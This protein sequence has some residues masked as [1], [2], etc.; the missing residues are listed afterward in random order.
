M[1]FL[2]KI[3]GMLIQ[4][5]LTAAFILAVIG[6]ALVI[7][8][9]CQQP[10]SSEYGDQF[11]DAPEPIKPLPY[12]AWQHD[13]A[14]DPPKQ[15]TFT[16]KFVIAHVALI[17]ATVYDSEATHQGIAHHKCLEQN[18]ALPSRPSRADLYE[19]GMIPVLVMTGFDILVQSRHFEKKVG[20]IAYMAP[21]YGTAIHIYGAST[22]LQTGC[23]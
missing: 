14:G 12:G 6:I 13:S 22:W 15:K 1:R 20:W 11:P 9:H 10:G 3:V 19:E 23:W 5:M 17:G 4:A 8:S 18:S 7:D 21:I 16:K 2:A